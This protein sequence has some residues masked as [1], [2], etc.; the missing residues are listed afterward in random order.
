MKI[1]NA[2]FVLFFIN[3]SF[4]Q[5]FFEKTDLIDEFGDK[6]GEVQR[7]VAFGTFTNSATNN[8]PLRVHTILNIQHSYTLKE[9]EDSMIKEFKKMG[10]S[11]KSIK[12]FLKYSGETYKSQDNIKGFI[13]FDLYEYENNLPSMI[14]V[15]SG[16]IM[17][18]TSDGKKIQ[19]SL[20]ENSFSKNSIGITGYK[21]LTEG[22][23]GVKSQIKFGYYDWAQTEIYNAIVNATEP[24]MVV[25]ICGNST[26][27]FTLKQL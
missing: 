3:Y 9:F 6:T 21:E 18:K 19:A 10:E 11:D 1:L 13:N 25:I 8:S 22:S 27:K 24:I 14:G 17:I 16:S 7:N 23:M 20:G 15:K 5:S 26:Y 4:S 12:Q 2:L